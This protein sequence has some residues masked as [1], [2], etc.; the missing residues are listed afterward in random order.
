M[1][2]S[3][4]VADSLGLTQSELVLIRQQQQI[5]AQ[6][7]HHGG[8]VADRGRGTSRQSNPSSRAGSAASSQSG[9]ILLDPHSLQTLSTYLDNVLRT[10]QR[11]IQQLED[12]TEQS[13]SSSSGRAQSAMHN[14]DSEITRM[15]RILAEI[16]AL[17]EE[18][19]KIKR[20]R[21]KVKHYRNNVDALSERLERTRISGHGSGTRHRR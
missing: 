2:A 16:D 15:R 1:S 21:D 4:S 17:E 19:A 5:M 12:A 9:R 18:F 8:G 6:R 3:Q 20:I 13:V 10:I 7:S 11:R 14:A